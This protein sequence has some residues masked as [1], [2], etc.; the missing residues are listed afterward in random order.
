[1]ER[2]DAAQ[3]DISFVGGGGCERDD[4][5]RRADENA[6]HDGALPVRAGFQLR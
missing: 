1:M 6:K 3:H 5:E 4:A 2:A